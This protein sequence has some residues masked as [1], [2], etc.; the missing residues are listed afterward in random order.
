MGSSWPRSS[1]SVC[2]RPDAELGTRL[3]RTTRWRSSPA[4][5]VPPI[6]PARPLGRHDVRP[7]RAGIRCG[8]ATSTCWSTAGRPAT[9]RRCS[10]TAGRDRS[11]PGRRRRS[12][13]RARGCSRTSSRS[14]R[15]SRATIRGDRPR[16][17]VARR[18]RD[19]ALTARRVDVRGAHRPQRATARGR[20]RPGARADVPDGGGR[21]HL[22]GHSH[23][24]KVATV[25]AIALDRPPEQLT[26]LDSPENV[27]AQLPGRGEPPR[28]LPPAAADRP[29]AGPDVRRQLLLD[30]RGALR[31]VPGAPG[32]GRRPARPR[33]VRRSSASTTS[34]RATAYPVAWY[35]A[36]AED[37][38]AG[39]GL[40]WS[41]L[42]GTPPDCRVCF[43]RQDWTGPD[44]GVVRADELRLQPASAR[45]RPPPGTGDRSRTAGSRRDPCA[46]P[47]ARSAP[48]AWCSRHPGS[49]LWQV[50]F[51][52]NP[53]D[54]AIEFDDRF[55]APGRRR[56]ARR[57]G[58]TTAR[59]SPLRRTGR[60]RPATTRS[61]T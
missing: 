22:I 59:C 39:V 24:A 32:G 13:R 60:A 9:S 8:P 52:R 47:R 21:I 30:H 25:A 1:A 26:L 29:R 42:I 41:P 12:T 2:S 31:H 38:A 16:L 6:E 37:L 58:S 7:G 55:T 4:P 15:R 23:G 54:L 61:S 33:A 43:F 56:A 3:P 46:A 36:S 11:S 40:A 51:D 35:T 10:A 50:E 27:L 19:R 57:S 20:A 53:D 17:L 48:T 45:P 18:L 49:R 14:R 28:G 34:S 44:G 5:E